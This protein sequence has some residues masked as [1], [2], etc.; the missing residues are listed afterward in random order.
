MVD[1]KHL[2]DTFVQ[3]LPK[4]VKYESTL[5]FNQA[6]DTH[7]LGKRERGINLASHHPIIIVLALLLLTEVEV[8]K[9]EAFVREELHLTATDG[10]G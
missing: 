4:M 7:L 2:F 9:G 3:V 6:T 1:A 8:L 10:P 5:L